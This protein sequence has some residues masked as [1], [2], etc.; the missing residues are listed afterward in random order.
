M[1]FAQRQAAIVGLYAT[2][3]VPNIACS[4]AALEIEALRGALDDA[5]LTV[6]D[7]D[8]IA[9]TRL[10]SPVAGSYDPLYFWPEQLGQRAITYMGSAGTGGLPAGALAKGALAVSAGM[11][12]VFV[13]VHGKSGSKINQAK[14]PMPTTAPRVGAW[15]EQLCGATRASWFALWAQRY[16]H[17]FGITSEQLAQVA[18]DARYHA[19]LNPASIMGHKG[20]ITIED[21]VTS[22]M[23]ASPFRLLDCALDNDGGYAIVVTTA[24]RARDLRKPPVYIL[25]AAEA[26]YVDYYHNVPYPLFR[27]EG[28]AVRS[29]ANIAFGM[30]G[31]KRSDVDVAGLYDCFT[32]T[33]LRDLEEMGFCDIGAGAAYVAE[34]HTRL[35]GSM[36]VNTDGG[37]LSSSHNGHPGGMHV[38]EV[39]R[40]LRREV[41]PARQVP[42][43]KIGAALSQGMAIHGGAGVLVMGV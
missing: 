3:Q 36:P 5:G 27:G 14:A 20:E 16:M 33:T 37:C 29:A 43:A 10:Q 19:T 31:V 41:A 18:V 30:A 17:E 12:E 42:D 40:Q 7:V 23:I 32:V 11:C 28:S 39:A 24:E 25:G 38:I 15:S 13:L 2:E 21:V 26:A 1:P 35:G 34:G 8:G 22:R 9:T 6:A 4:G